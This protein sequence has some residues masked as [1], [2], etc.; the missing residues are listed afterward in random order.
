MA[1]WEKGLAPHQAWQF[2][3]NRQDP[4]VG[5]IELFKGVL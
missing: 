3:F 2:E 5:K 1:Q 4:H